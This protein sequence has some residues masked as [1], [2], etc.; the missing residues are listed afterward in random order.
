M[1]L[2]AGS[3]SEHGTSTSIC[4]EDHAFL[5]AYRGCY[6]SRCCTVECESKWSFSMGFF[7]YHQDQVDSQLEI[8]RQGW[9]YLACTLPLTFVALGVAFV[10]MWW[11]ST[12]LEKPFDYHAGQV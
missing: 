10:W 11:R 2:P 4:G 12:K 7:N 3:S 5:A 6:A 8:S 9:I 1:S